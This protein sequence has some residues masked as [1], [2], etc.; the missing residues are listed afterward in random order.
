MATCQE[1]GYLTRMCDVCRATATVDVSHADVELLGYAP[2]NVSYGDVGGV[3]FFLEKVVELHA[4]ILD[5][6]AFLGERGEGCQSHQSAFE[7]ADG[8]CDVLGEVLKNFIA[9][10]GA[11]P[12][13]ALLAQN[14]DAG[15]EVRHVERNGQSLFEAGCKAVIESGDFTRGAVGGENNLFAAGEK[16]VEGVEELFLRFAFLGEELNVIN[17]QNVGFAVL[18]T[19]VAQRVTLTG[20]GI[21]ICIGEIFAGDIENLHAVVFLANGVADGLQKVGLAQA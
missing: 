7:S 21:N 15:F 20:D 11:L 13:A 18:A 14:G 17:Q 4:G 19:E 1:H 16:R 6:R 8:A 12:K 3:L 9:D 5:G 10:E 2:L